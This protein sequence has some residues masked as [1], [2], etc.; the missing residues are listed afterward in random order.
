[1]AKLLEIDEKELLTI[2]LAD[3]VGF[4]SDLVSSTITYWFSDQAI[5]QPDGHVSGIASGIVSEP[6]NYLSEKGL[7]FVK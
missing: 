3:K 4:A 2:W 5:R 6:V 7:K 1:M